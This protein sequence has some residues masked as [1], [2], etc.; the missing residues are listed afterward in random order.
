MQGWRLPED[1]RNVFKEPIGTKIKES[2]LKKL[3]GKRVITVGDVVSLVARRNGI[4]PIL[5]IYDGLTERREMTGFADLVTEQGLEEKV[6]SNP[7]GTITAELADAIKQTQEGKPGII[8]VIGEEDL[9]LMPCIL[10]SADGT[11]IIYGWPGEGIMHVTADC[12]SRERVERL[13]KMME[14]IE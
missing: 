7:A 12:S 6:V 4:A 10:Y 1:K 9:A 13:W 5:S 11:E 8:R 3:D 2:E 14:E